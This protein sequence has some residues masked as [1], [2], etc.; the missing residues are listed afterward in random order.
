MATPHGFP[1]YSPWDPRGTFHG[2]SVNIIEIQTYCMLVSAQSV[3]LKSKCIVRLFQRSPSETLFGMNDHPIAVVKLPLRP[4]AYFFIFY[5]F[6]SVPGSI[7]TVQFLKTMFFHESSSYSRCN[8]LV[9]TVC[10]KFRVL[11]ICKGH[12]ADF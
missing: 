1:W 7:Y 4:S 3:I 11:S 9:K 8:A 12:G 5:R 10:R 2:G 6:R